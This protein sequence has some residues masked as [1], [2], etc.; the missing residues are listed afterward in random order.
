MKKRIIFV[1]GIIMCMI[2]SVGIFTA[3]GSEPDEPQKHTISFYADAALVGR[4]ETAGNE[5]I[6]LPAAPDKDGHS[7]EG[8]FSI[9]GPGRSN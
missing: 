5:E 3:C 4:V 1:L 2:L 6:G 7:F 9:P 8:W